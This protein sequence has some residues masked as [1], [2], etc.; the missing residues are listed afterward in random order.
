MKKVVSILLLAFIIFAAQYYLKNYTLVLIVWTL[1]GVLYGMFNSGKFLF[2]IGFLIQLLI[3]SYIFFQ[4]DAGSGDYIE[5]ILAE[6]GISRF[7]L[8]L[9]VI[10]FNALSVGFCLLLGI[11]LF[12]L[13]KQVLQKG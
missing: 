11:N 10:V 8:L 9:I 5:M 6:Y 4:M 3:G 1:S 12:R 2:G 7:L 13:G